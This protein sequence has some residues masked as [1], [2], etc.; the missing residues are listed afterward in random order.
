M[1]T[2]LDWREANVPFI[3]GISDTRKPGREPYRVRPLG[4]I[5][6][7]A[8]PYKLPKEN[9]FAFIPSLYA[10]N[11]ARSHGVQ[12]QHGR[13]VALVGDIDQGNHSLSAIRDAIA[14]V[15]GGCA[16]TIYSTASA[17]PDDKRW[18]IIVP[19]A[20]PAPYEVWHDAQLAL[21]DLMAG[22]FIDMDSCATRPGQISFLPNV[23]NEARG[24]DGEPLFFERTC[25]DTAAPG[26]SLAHGPVAQAM[27]AI[28][29]KR[30][31]DEAERE[32]IRAEAA[33]RKASRLANSGGGGSI[34]EAFCRGNDLNTLLERYGYE[35][36]PRDGRDWRSPMQ[37]SKSF[38]T[39]VIEDGKW[40]S[41]SGSDAASGLGEQCS[42]GCFGDA[43]DLFVHFEYNGDRTAALR[44]LHQDRQQSQPAFRDA[45]FARSGDDAV[46]YDPATGTFRDK[47][48]KGD[49]FAEGPRPL[50]R[51]LGAPAEFP[52]NALGQTL[53]KA[54]L[55]IEAIVQL[56]MAAAANS[57]LAVASL[58][59]Q[60]VA[61]VQL[62]IG[63]GETSP[64]SLFI[65]TV[66]DSGDRKST[67]DKRALKPV[68]EI[69]RRLMEVESRERQKFEAELA[70]YETHAKHLKT[71]LKGN[72]HALEAA[73]IDLGQPPR[74]PLA[75]VIAPS[76]DQTME[77][78][79][80]IYQHGRPSLAMLCDDAGTFLG[81]HSLKAEQKQSTTGNLCRAW[82]GAKLERIRGGDGISV[83]HD[84][85]LAMHLMAQEGVATEFLADERFSDQG[86]LA[87]FLIAAPKSLAGT[88]F[89]DDAYEAKARHAETQLQPYFDAIDRL[90][91]NPVQWKDPANPALGV[92]MEALALSRE[93]TDIWKAFVNEVEQGQASGGPL[94]GAKAFASKL[95]MNAARIAGIITLVEDPGVRIVEADT[96]RNAIEICRYYLSETLRLL[97]AA[98][99][100]AELKQASR[101]LGW[102]QERGQSPIGHATIYQNGP[103]NIRDAKTARAAME[104]LAAH[105]WARRVP[106]GAEIDGTRFRE[107]WEVASRD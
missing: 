76:G 81:G 25:S 17:K 67:A 89:R 51:D 97:G 92:E 98:V 57:V 106:G 18:R 107:A 94:A 14:G 90:A 66:L 3:A 31:L 105:G 10:A 22:E 69:E 87:R 68:R 104:V 2:A 44:E 47:P 55:G 11:D 7:T 78:L 32:R 101:L 77:G 13:F 103:S 50:F 6:S 74:P 84:R 64:L 88:R 71:K 4:E 62:P 48:G 12:R 16:W 56:P 28:R 27:T 80:R 45:A 85:R 60:G 46:R 29:K 75:S 79:F 8:S 86:L 70:A 38:A 93:A 39:R 54:A 33:R 65:L 19:L 73:L 30:A 41:L 100:S 23:P 24:S 63:A 42:S 40:I 37:T 5:L 21:I 102:L 59:A 26:L 91:G 82:D 20:E 95:P 52:V 36:N 35:R 61:D 96:L 72:R 34:I 53:G 43:F 9:A 99:V 83:L 49:A 58:A 15:A 1:S